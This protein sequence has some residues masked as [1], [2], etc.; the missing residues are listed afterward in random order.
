VIGNAAYREQED[1][2]KELSTPIRDAEEVAKTLRADFGFEIEI[3]GTTAEEKAFPLLLRNASRSGILRALQRLARTAERNDSVIVYYAGHGYKDE[4]IGASYWVPIGAKHDDYTDWISESDW[5]GQVRSF[6]ARHVLVVADSCYAGAI[7]TRGGEPPAQ[8]P[9]EAEARRRFIQNA[10]QRTSRNLLASGANEPVA[11]KGGSGH[12]VFASAF[13]TWLR[14]YED[15]FF[16]GREVFG[17]IQP[18]VA[19]KVAQLP[20]YESLRQSGH[21]GGDFVFV[22]TPAGPGKVP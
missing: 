14:E 18:A 21:E 13:L 5:N 9:P 7:V 16:T 20:Q 11:D 6:E 1:G 2:W 17:K 15:S 10:I 19:G 8:P 12:S 4:K 22:R 3:P